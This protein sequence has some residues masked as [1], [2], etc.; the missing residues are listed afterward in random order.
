MMII[1]IIIIIM[2]IMIIIMI[3]FILS[4]LREAGSSK[5]YMSL[6]PGERKVLKKYFNEIDKNQNG[7]IEITE[8]RKFYMTKFGVDLSDNDL[9]SMVREADKNKNR[10]IDLL[11]YMRLIHLLLLLLLLLL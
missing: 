9:I 10:Y 1:I 2:I 11:S 5:Y 7:K 4:A 3:I 8:L 6:T